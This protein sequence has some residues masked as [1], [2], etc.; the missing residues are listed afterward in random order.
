MPFFRMLRKMH[1][2]EIHRLKSTEYK[3][4]FDGSAIYF[5]IRLLQGH[6]SLLY[7]SLTNS[8]NSHFKIFFQGEKKQCFQIV[9]ISVLLP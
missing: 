7:S 2:P 3:K 5:T 6:Y 9:D 4:A 8:F 1:L